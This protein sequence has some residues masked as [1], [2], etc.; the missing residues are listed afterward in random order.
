[1]FIML[2]VQMFM[3]VLINLGA[4]KHETIN[5][6]YNSDLPITDPLLPT[7]CAPLTPIVNWVNRCVISIFIVF[8][9]SFVPLA[10]QELTE[11]G[12]WR[13][14]TRLAKHFGSFSFMFEVFVCQIYAN[15]VHQ[16][17]S[18]G[19]ARYIG[20]GRG[21]ATA[22][23][24]FGVLY[25]RFAGPSIY[26]GSRLLLMLLFSTSTVWT[27]SLIW[28][29][30]SLLAL[31]ISPFLFNPHQFA[32]NDFFI[33]YRD[34]IRWLSRGNSRSHASSWIGFCRLSRT[35]IT[36]YKRKLLGVPS[37]KGSGD[38]PRARITNIFFSE[39]VAPLVLVGVTL[40]PYLFINSRT[41]ITDDADGGNDPA[42]A[43]VRIAIVAFGPIGINAGVSGVFFG[44]ACCM[45]PLLSMCCKKFGA[46]LA[47][48]AHAVAVII[49]LVIFEVMFFLEGWSWPRCLMG[50]IAMAAIQR[51]I[52]KLIIS[53]ALTRE[54]KHDQSNIAWW[55]GKWYNMGWH[56][57]SQPGREFLCKIT[58]LGYFAADFVIG[59]IILFVMLPALCVPYIDTF[60][61]V[62]LFW[63][64]PR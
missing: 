4:L 14:A 3:I 29:W 55:T 43:I 60:H 36:G 18:F 24:P 13:M 19:G 15:A 33:D 21:F 54:F 16:N 17:L 56:S 62:I 51:F 53:L 46:V 34:Y 52:Y 6:Y 22:R 49:L 39:I 63:L 28:F 8:F 30:V 11:R 48:I 35:R 47:A 41:G 38:I 2:S 61:S 20:T 25:S 10:V 9:I 58:E 1:M 27:A 31:C 50:M 45:G 32:W 23:I 42:N 12:L 37:E 44:M 40:V 64:R 5:C 7:F 57:L 59:H 26:A